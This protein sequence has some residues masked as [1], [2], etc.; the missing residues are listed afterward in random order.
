MDKYVSV[1]CAQCSA[2]D[3]TTPEVLLYVFFSD[4]NIV[5]VLVVVLD[6]SVVELAAC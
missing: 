3:Y 5:S 2:H 4:M 1:I 6:S